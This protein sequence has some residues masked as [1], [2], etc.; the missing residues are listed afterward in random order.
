[1]AI[2]LLHFKPIKKAPGNTHENTISAG[3]C[4]FNKLQFQQS[5]GVL[6]LMTPMLSSPDE[7]QQ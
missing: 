2:R 1:M 6:I 7:D 4:A 3:H 5:V